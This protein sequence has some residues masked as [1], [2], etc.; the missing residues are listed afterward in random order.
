VKVL[1]TRQAF[2]RLAEIQAFVAAN[3][4]GATERLVARLVRRAEALVRSPLMGRHVPEL[5]GSE[6]REL[7]EGNYR[8][9]YRRIAY[10]A[11]AQ[12]VEILTVF[13]GH[14]RFPRADI[15]AGQEGPGSP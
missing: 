2:L 4:P 11:G 7:V 8:I 13:E 14:R 6:L 15:D 5:P 9:V 1:W 10:R 12:R 3:R